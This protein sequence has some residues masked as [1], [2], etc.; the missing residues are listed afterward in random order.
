[1][2]Y[3]RIEPEWLATAVNHPFELATASN[4]ALAGRRLRSSGSGDILTRARL[5][6]SLNARNCTARVYDESRP[7][8]RGKR[9]SASFSDASVE[10]RA[11]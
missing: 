3:A 4:C 2:R 11:T 9:T 1:M 5:L 8:T 10:T 6:T 7:K